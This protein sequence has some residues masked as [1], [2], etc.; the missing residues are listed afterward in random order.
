MTVLPGMLSTTRTLTTESARAMS[1]AS[2]TIWL[3]LMPGAG[4]ISKRVITGPGCTAST[5]TSMLKSA[6]FFST[7]R[8]MVSSA[9]VE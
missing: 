8:D 9:S 2:E 6:S 3:A 1:R 7:R 4:S 5:R